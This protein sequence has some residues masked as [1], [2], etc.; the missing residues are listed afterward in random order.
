MKLNKKTLIIAGIAVLALV[1]LF[2]FGGP[3]I[4][5]FITDLAGSALGVENTGTPT[6]SGLAVN[7]P[8][9][10]PT[11]KP[12]ATPT[13]K[14]T[15]GQTIEPTKAETG[16]TSAPYVAYYFRNKS[17]LDSHYDKHG[18]DMGFKSAKDYEKAASDVIN[19]PTALHKTEK[20][21][22]DTCYYIVATNEFVVLSTDG[23]IRT[24]FL[25]DAGKAYY[26]RQ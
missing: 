13:P 25:P 17:L 4:R 5:K 8:S 6:D 12:D 3:G 22:G 1:L 16:P 15:E 2:V 24:Y 26:D 19:N 21:D 9:K 18:K 20:E 14:P 7:D 23:Y 10:A 11:K